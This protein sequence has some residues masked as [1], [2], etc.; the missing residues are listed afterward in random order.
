MKC[1]AS[2]LISLAIA[3]CA[4]PPPG[5]MARADV[6]VCAK[7]TPTGSN[8]PVT[9]CRSAAQIERD[10]IEAATLKEEIHHK[11]ANPHALGGAR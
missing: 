9:R 2:V 7:E 10:R 6:Q 1:L 3:G 8:V 5:S 4:S 11:A